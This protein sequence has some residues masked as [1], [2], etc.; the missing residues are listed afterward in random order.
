[1]DAVPLYVLVCARCAVA[2]FVCRRDY[3]GQ[4][5]CP[6]CQP[7]ERAAQHR[8]ANAR[9]QRSDEGRADHVDH[10]R[11]YRARKLAESEAVT[12]TASRKLATG[13]ECI[14][15]GGVVS[16][17]TGSDASAEGGAHGVVHG[18]HL[19]VGDADAG[20]R[21]TVLT[22]FDPRRPKFLTTFD[23]L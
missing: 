22:T 20:A 7:L 6:T 16:L 17:Q 18:G 2:F 21:V 10:Q 14:S 1:M 19:A 12:G 13:A 8:L 3:R 15:P 23:P 4:T 9:H 5:Y 11:A